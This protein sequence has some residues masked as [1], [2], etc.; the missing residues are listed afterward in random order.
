MATPDAIKKAYT[1]ALNKIAGRYANMEDAVINRALTMLNELQNQLAADLVRA[2][3]AQAADPALSTF[4]PWR[5]QDL[6]RHITRLQQEFESRLSAELRAAIPEIYTL[7]GESVVAPLTAAGIG[8][9]FHVPNRAQINILLDF[10]TD[11]VKTATRDYFPTIAAEVR[12]A[13]L[14]QK[15]PLDAMTAITRKV[16]F[17]MDWKVGHPTEGVAYNAER[18]L[19]TEVQRVYNLANHSQLMAT[20]KQIPGLKK[21][22]I[23]TA[24]S[25]TR[26]GHLRIHNETRQ[27]PIPIDQPFKVYDIDDRGRIKSSAELMYPLDPSAPPEFTINCR[28]RQATI[29]P[30]IGIIKSNLDGRIAGQIARREQEAD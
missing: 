24:D 20:G 27:N 29:H 11:L 12:L 13:A 16:G 19:R 26:S 7:G 30:E 6:Q 3:A 8:G 28:C 22:W 5:I 17:P 1:A 9:A 25:R 21:R 14:G 4:T 2:L 18:I 23:A 10:T 15:S